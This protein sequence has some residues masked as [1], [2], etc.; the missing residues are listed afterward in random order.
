MPD[1]LNT[2]EY[3]TFCPEKDDSHS[4]LLMTIVLLLCKEHRITQFKNYFSFI[5]F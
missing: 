3:P 1:K 5:W 4:V 2:Q